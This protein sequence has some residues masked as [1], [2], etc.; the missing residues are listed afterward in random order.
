LPS[1]PGAAPQPGFSRL[2]LGQSASLVGSQVTVVALPL[3]AIL[4]LHAG[5]REMGLLRVAQAAPFLL[6]GLLAGAWV[7]R[8][9]RLSLLTLGSAGQAVLLALV[10]ALALTHHL[11]I[12]LLYGVGFLVGIL[13]VL[14]DVSFQAL[15]PSLVGRQGLVRANS[16]LETSR[17]VAQVVGPSLGGLLVQLV[18]APLAILV[19]T[20]SFL[21]AA[22]MVR[23]IRDP[24][25]PPR[26]AARRSLLGDVRE[27][28]TAL[29]GQ[30]VLRAITVAITLSNV[31]VSVLVPV[32][33]LF[34]VRDLHLSPYVVGVAV[35]VN[36][37]GGIVGAIAGGR[38]GRLPMAVIQGLGLGMSA[39]ATLLI[40]AATGPMALALGL[41]LA[42]EALF[43]FAVPFT[44]VNQLS[45]RQALTPAHL[46]ARVHATSRTL[47]WGAIPIGALLG[48]QLGEHVGLRPTLVISGLGTLAAALVAYVGVMAAT[49]RTER[50][51]PNE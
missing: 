34:M 38:A 36:G 26:P 6:L 32:L 15:V 37:L 50:A 31:S 27:G 9:S 16:R 11:A 46:Q 12:A 5:P 23:T 49:R 42:G 30:P 20:A 24:G 35:S 51:E 29:L 14:T 25:V 10:P 48:G 43:G 2:W 39:T 18:S 17:S 40:A 22:G 13:T 21:F 41:L 33:F 3:T 28:L 7:D 45:L 1:T 4:T 19:D 47:T 44:N 8:R